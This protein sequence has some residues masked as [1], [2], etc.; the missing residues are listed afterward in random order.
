MKG[1]ES[2][3]GNKVRSERNEEEINGK[4]YPQKNENCW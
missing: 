4:N 1:E 3:K 2:G